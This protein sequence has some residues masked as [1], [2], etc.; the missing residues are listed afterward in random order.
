M[1]RDLITAAVLALAAL[2]IAAAAALADVARGQTPCGYAPTGPGEPPSPWYVEDG[3]GNPRPCPPEPGTPPT[4]I[5][6]PPPPLP[7][8]PVRQILFPVFR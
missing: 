7:D 8:Y 2:L 4:P 5:P 1:R 6:E 3:A